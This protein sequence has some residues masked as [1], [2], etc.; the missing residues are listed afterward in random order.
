MNPDYSSIVWV[1]L[2]KTLVLFRM[3]I[4]LESGSMLTEYMF[5]SF[6]FSTVIYLRNL[7]LR[8]CY[9]WM[10]K[11][12]TMVVSSDAVMFV[13]WMILFLWSSFWCIYVRI[14]IFSKCV[15]PYP[16]WSDLVY[17]LYYFPFQCPFSEGR[18]V[19]STSILIPLNSNALYHH[20]TLR[21]GLSLTV[22][23]VC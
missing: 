20:L 4:F 16:I 6:F 2:E 9:S 1:I 21:F 7:L 12:F 17:H 22:M 3:F 18:T 13:L 8:F 23:K 15:F 11:L 10:L 19:S 14:D 5:G